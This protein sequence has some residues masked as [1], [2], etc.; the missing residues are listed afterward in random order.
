MPKATDLYKD[1]HG[2]NPKGRMVEYTSPVPPL[3]AIGELQDLVYTPYGS[4]MRKGTAFSH[5]SGDIGHKVLK[6]NLLLCTD[7]TGRN[8]FLVKKNPKGRYPVFSSRGILG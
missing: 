6:T 5:K 1:F 2:A 3:I 7:S 8:L 4:S